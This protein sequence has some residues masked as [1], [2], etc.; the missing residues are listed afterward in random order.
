MRNLKILG[1]S[2]RGNEANSILNIHTY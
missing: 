2:E 1:A